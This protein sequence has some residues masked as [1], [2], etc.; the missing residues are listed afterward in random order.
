MDDRII[1]LLE[2]ANAM[3]GIDTALIDALDA[4]KDKATTRYASYRRLN[5]FIRGFPVCPSNLST[6]DN[7][8]IGV[9]TID[10]D[11][12]IWVTDKS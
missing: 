11:N 3:E 2:K 7:N 8:R 6:D 10:N 5:Q 1:R 9:A 12:R 4:Q